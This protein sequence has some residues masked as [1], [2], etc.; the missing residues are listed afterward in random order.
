[1]LVAQPSLAV[2]KPKEED[3]KSVKLCLEFCVSLKSSKATAKRKQIK[4]ALLLFLGGRGK[5]LP[6]AS[7][8]KKIGEIQT[9][10]TKE[11]D[12]QRI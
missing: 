4:K 10:E 6:V 12:S 2:I 9:L 5:A 7:L 1:M 3:L 8:L 11:P